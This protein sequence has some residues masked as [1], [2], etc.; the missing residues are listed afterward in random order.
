MRG[1]P[2]IV[3]LL[4]YGLNQLAVA[5]VLLPI[6]LRPVVLGLLLTDPSAPAFDIP[7]E[8]VVTVTPFPVQ[9]VFRGRPRN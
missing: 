5:V 3:R 7:E 1:C 6:P 9:D 8:G 2:S 4:A